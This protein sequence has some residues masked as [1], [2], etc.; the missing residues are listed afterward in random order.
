MLEDVTEIHMKIRDRP[1]DPSNSIK[2][3]LPLLHYSS[4]MSVVMKDDEQCNIPILHRIPLRHPWRKLILTENLMNSWIL[5]IDDDEP[6]TAQEAQ[7]ALEFLRSKNL[8]KCAIR[9]HKRTALNGT[10]LNE[11]RSTF[12]QFDN[13][14]PA[15]ICTPETKFVV[16]SAEPIENVNH[17]TCTLRSPH[18]QH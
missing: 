5:A 4:P 11:H 3:C 7:D 6:I 13:S 2:L 1:C 18:R 14:Y 8:S 17:F 12:D 15:I 16:N 10:L 9:L